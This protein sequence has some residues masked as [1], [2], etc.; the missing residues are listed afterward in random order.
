[1][2]KWDT[3][4]LCRS[5]SQCK[6]FD[7]G[8][9]GLRQERVTVVLG[10]LIVGKRDGHEIDRCR[11]YETTTQITCIRHRKPSCREL[12][13]GINK[14]RCGFHLSV[15]LGGSMSALCQLGAESA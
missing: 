8:T 13:E 5:V 9:N 3:A 1:M 2:L 10:P 15:R 11:K 12:A 6:L 14:K 4:S 7:A